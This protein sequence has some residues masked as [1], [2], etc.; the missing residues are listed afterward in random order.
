MLTG[1]QHILHDYGV[2]FSFVV[3]NLVAVFGIMI[4]PFPAFYNLLRG[5]TQSALASPIEPDF[6]FGE[7]AMTILEMI[8][9]FGTLTFVIGIGILFLL[10]MATIR[11]FQKI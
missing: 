11:A 10:L 9:G 5:F 4:T 1:L 2:L 8:P 3:D 6:S 7:E